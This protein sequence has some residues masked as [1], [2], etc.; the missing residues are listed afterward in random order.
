[1]LY[2]LRY[3]EV[4]AQPRTADVH[5]L[6]SN[7][8]VGL[9][10]KHGIG[11]LGFWIPKIGFSN[12]VPCMLVFED[13]GDREDKLRAFEADPE[14]QEAQAEANKHRWGPPVASVRS[15]LLQPTPYSP[16]PRIE[17]VIQEFRT[18]EAMPGRIGD[19]HHLFENN[20]N[21]YLFPRYDIR[22]VGWFNEAVGTSD[23]ILF[24]M[25]F[26]TIGDRDTR[27]TE[28]AKDPDFRKAAPPYEKEG[29]LRRRSYHRF[30]QLADYTPRSQYVSAPLVGWQDKGYAGDTQ[31][32]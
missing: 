31:R 27:F 15:T 16:E 26:P 21:A 13:L 6:F 28:L 5:N 8:A 7:H 3:Y 23:R 11:V 17:R 10:K 22:I 4:T 30:F 2:E 32:G 18:N 9:L 29:P 19:L 14:W 20:H 25:E 12:E 24:I 1:M